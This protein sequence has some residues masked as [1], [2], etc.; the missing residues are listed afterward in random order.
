MAFF[1]K[2][3]VLLAQSNRQDG[4]VTRKWMY[5]TTDAVA[6]VTA[7]GYY[8]AMRARLTV[9]DTIESSVGIGGTAATLIQRVATVP[10]TGNVTTTTVLNV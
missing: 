10:G 9:G 1:D 7:A 6:T 5:S 2:A 3:F 8:N 4:S